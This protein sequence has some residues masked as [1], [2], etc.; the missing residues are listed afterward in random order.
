MLTSASGQEIT[1]Q[2]RKARPMTRMY[3]H[4]GRMR[5]WAACL[6]GVGLRDAGDDLASGLLDLDVLVADAGDELGQHGQ[7]GVLRQGIGQAVDGAE[8]TGTH[9]PYLRRRPQD[10]FRAQE[11]AP[12]W[13][14]MRLKMPVHTWGTCTGVQKMA[15]EH[16]R[17][18]PHGHSCG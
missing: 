16:R 1:H 17:E 13:A 8:D 18:H 12:A 2:G 7:P 11:E 15:S 4:K 14:L 10:G 5:V 3:T 6:L 9:L